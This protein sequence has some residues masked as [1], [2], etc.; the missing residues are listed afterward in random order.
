MKELKYTIH[1]YIGWRLHGRAISHIAYEGLLFGYMISLQIALS[2]RP[3]VPSMD[4]PKAAMM[5][6]RRLALAAWRRAQPILIT[7]PVI[8]RLVDA[9]ESHKLDNARGWAPDWV[10][11][12]A[13]Q[14]APSWIFKNAGYAV[15]APAPD[16]DCESD[17][18]SFT[19]SFAK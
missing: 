14:L 17:D 8:A 9:I 15:V 10:P 19:R 6:A 18:E 11:E 3:S 1:H 4:A 5:R 12:W 16:E 2:R 7:V 13:V